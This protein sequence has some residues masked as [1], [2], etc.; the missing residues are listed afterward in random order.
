[1]IFNNN[2]KISELYI[3]GITNR[4]RN[5]VKMFVKFVQKWEMNYVIMQKII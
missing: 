3:R 4:N 2:T 5:S 1:M